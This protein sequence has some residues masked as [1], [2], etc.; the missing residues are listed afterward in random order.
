MTLCSTSLVPP[1]MGHYLAAA[2]PGASLEIESGE[3]HVL[4]GPNGS[5]KSTLAH[6]LMGRPEYEVTS[7]SVTID[8]PSAVISRLMTPCRLPAPLLRVHRTGYR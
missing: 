7:G 6:A 4:M 5:G 2:I 8:G 1:A 3:V